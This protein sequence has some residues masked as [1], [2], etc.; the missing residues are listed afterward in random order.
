[1]PRTAPFEACAPR[2]EAWLERHQAAYLSELLA[3]RAFLPWSGQGLEIG[4][5]SARFAAP[6]SIAVGI[7]P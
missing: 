5:G 4:V 7:D 6:L 1:M 3:L 2:Y